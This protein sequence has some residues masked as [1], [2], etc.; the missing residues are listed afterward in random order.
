MRWIGLVVLAACA[1]ERAQAVYEVATRRASLA[2]STDLGYDIEI[3]ELRLAL[4]HAAFII[5]DRV[6]GETTGEGVMEYR[7]TGR[8]RVTFAEADDGAY[9]AAR[10]TFRTS[11]EIEGQIARVSGT[12]SGMPFEAFVEDP[13]DLFVDLAFDTTLAGQPDEGVDWIEIRFVALAT[14]FDGIE[15]AALPIGGSG[16]REIRAGGVAHELLRGQL[17]Q[18]GRFD[19]VHQWGLSPPP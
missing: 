14:L 3:S 7:E 6:G 10:L 4:A 8:T 1:S 2:V 5:G 17:F 12:A 11:A 16:K 19:A 15:F 18:A 13:Q 9:R